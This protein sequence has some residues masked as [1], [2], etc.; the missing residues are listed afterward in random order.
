ME[1]AAETIEDLTRCQLL[2]ILREIRMIYEL[3]GSPMDH[4]PHHL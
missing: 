2:F 1:L 4:F 3:L